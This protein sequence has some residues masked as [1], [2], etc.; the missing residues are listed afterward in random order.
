MKQKF[1][2]L[3]LFIFLY[4][5]PLFAEDKYTF[6]QFANETVDFV[7]QPVKWTGD[8]YLKIGLITAGTV[9]VTFADQPFRN[10][11]QKVTGSKNTILMEGGR[12]YGELF[13]PCAFFGGFAVFSLITGD[14]WSRKVAYEIGQAS[15]Y[16]GGLVF[17]L[18]TAIGRARPYTDRGPGTYRPFLSI[19]NQEYHSLPGGHSTAATIISTVL[20]RNVKPVWLKILFYAPAVITMISRA[21][22]DQHWASD[23]VLG[24]AI[25]FYIATWC[26]D[27]HEKPDTKDT[28]QSLMD[29]IQLQPMIMGNIYGLNLSI[30]LF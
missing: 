5:S 2:F 26:V 8:D 6:T 3:I 25:G 13:S 15:L 19:F 28:G 10:M 18:K 7:V 17:I 1:L 9:A 12:W 4:E 30:R 11:E 22:Q 27:K 29:R 21:Y 14:V 16:G 20:S 23:N 24:A